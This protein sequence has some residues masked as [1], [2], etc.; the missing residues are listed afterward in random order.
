MARRRTE[1]RTRPARIA[2]RRVRWDLRTPTAS[3]LRE[4]MRPAPT[5]RPRPLVE[6]EAGADTTMG[7]MRLPCQRSTGGRG[8]ARVW[9]NTW[10][11]GPRGQPRRATSVGSSPQ[12]RRSRAGRR[13]RGADV[14]VPG[15]AHDGRGSDRGAPRWGALRGGQGAVPAGA[16][17]ATPR[18]L[19]PPRPVR[20]AITRATTGRAPAGTTA[21]P[22]SARGRRHDR[23]GNAGDPPSTPLRAGSPA[24]PASPGAA[25]RP[26]PRA[27]ADARATGRP[28]AAVRA[29]SVEVLG[30][31][32]IVAQRP[33]VAIDEALRGQARVRQRVE[34]RALDPLV[35]I[36]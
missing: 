5:A 26:R 10:H 3:V 9:K 24:P 7:S 27:R 19:K 1:G 35:G 18:L 32:E 25:A 34:D 21:P 31:V 16:P 13:H 2:R 36:M 29:G 15:H 17:G 12:R 30:V 6:R 28:T 14:R 22:R 33:R 8:S 20:R 4:G 11:A 23:R